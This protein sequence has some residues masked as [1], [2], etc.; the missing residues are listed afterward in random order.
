VSVSLPL[1][2]TTTKIIELLVAVLGQAA[3][4]INPSQWWLEVMSDDSRVLCDIYTCR[5]EIGNVSPSVRRCIDHRMNP[6]G[7]PENADG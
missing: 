4:H 7:L 6:A 2:E 5:F 3:S 1:A